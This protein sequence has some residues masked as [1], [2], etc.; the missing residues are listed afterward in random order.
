MEKIMVANLGPIEDTLSRFTEQV[1]MLA[2]DGVSEAKSGHTC[3]RTGLRDREQQEP[4]RKIVEGWR[5]NRR[6]EPSVQGNRMAVMVS[7][8]GVSKFAATK[9][10]VGQ[11]VWKIPRQRDPP[12]KHRGTRVLGPSGGSVPAGSGG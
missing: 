5:G 4:S 9:T 1:A 8:A 11:V 10:C 12:G 3:K 2:E 6:S 7:K